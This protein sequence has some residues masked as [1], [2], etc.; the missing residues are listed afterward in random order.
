[1]VIN[2][3]LALALNVKFKLVWLY[4]DDVTKSALFVVFRM[5]LVST[6]SLLYRYRL[7]THVLMQ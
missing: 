7:Q 6:A 2:I 3:N 5:S 4:D 1:M